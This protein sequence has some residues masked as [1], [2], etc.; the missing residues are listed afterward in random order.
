MLLEASGGNLRVFQK[1][2]GHARI[3]TTT[4]YADVVDEKTREGMRAMDQLAQQTM[5]PSRNPK[6]GRMAMQA[7][8]EDRDEAEVTV[9]P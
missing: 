2:L 7:L 4:V 3:T 5:K 9:D 6:P 8:E 1:A